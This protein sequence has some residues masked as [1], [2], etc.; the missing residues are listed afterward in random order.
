M[1]LVV[2]AEQSPN[3]DS[4]VTLDRSVDAFGMPR[5]RLN[6]Q[7]QD[8]DVHTVSEM[9]DALGR[10]AAKMGLGQVEKAEWLNGGAGT[11]AKLPS[12]AT[13]TRSVAEATRRD[14][15]ARPACA[16]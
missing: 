12:V 15:A 3:P 10:D 4:R 2:R 7:L 16:P 9:V 1:A 11:A 13:P 14:S 6:W 5:I 8:L